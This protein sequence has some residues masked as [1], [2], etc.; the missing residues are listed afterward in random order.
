[1][2]FRDMLGEPCHEI[3]DGDRLGNQFF[4]FMAM[5]M[6]GDK[7]PIIRVNARGCDNRSA[8]VASNVFDDLRRIALIGHSANV[9]AIFVIG[10]DR[11]FYLLK[12]IT[13]SG[14]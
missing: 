4:I 1:M 6:K 2:F 10:I 14:M 11:S 9:K 5:V 3:E 7:V 8:K 12:G 13:D